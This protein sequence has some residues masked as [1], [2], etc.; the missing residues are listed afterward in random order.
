MLITNKAYNNFINGRFFNEGLRLTFSIVLP[1]LFFGFLGYLQIGLFLSI[2][3]LLVSVTDSPGPINHRFNGMLVTIITT[4]VVSL[5][6][7]LI[8]PALGLLLIF[9][10]VFGFLFSM[11]AVF[12]ARAAAIGI[13]SLLAAILAMHQPDKDFSIIWKTVY[14]LCGA[15]W[16]LCIS[17][18]SYRIRP[19]KIV[20]QVMGEFVQDLSKY[21]HERA[22]FYDKNA[23]LSAVNQHLLEQQV[24]IQQQQATLSE[25]LYKTRALVNEST[26]KGR[27][28][29]KIY[30]DLVQL[31]ESIMT[32]FHSYNILHNVFDKTEVLAEIKANLHLLGNELFDLGIALKAERRVR[33]QP[34]L[35]EHR[36][37][38]KAKYDTLRKTQMQAGNLE[39]FVTLGRIIKN[40]ERM[41]MQVEDLQVYSSYDKS[42]VTRKPGHLPNENYAEKNDIRFSLLINNL[43]FA[44]NIF[45]HSIRVAL[46]LVVGLAVARSLAIGHGYWVLLTIA[47]ILKPAY[48]LTKQR[49]KD[50][51]LGTVLGLLLAFLIL[52]LAPGKYVLLALIIFFML[53]SFTFLRTNYFV[54]VLFMTAFIILF[55]FISFPANIGSLLVD[56]FIDTLIGSGIALIASLFIVP[57]WEKQEILNSVKLLLIGQS[58][59]LDVF[60]RIF[61][62]GEKVSMQE[63]R[64]SRREL[65]VSQANV[66]GAF[67]RML[68]EPKRFQKNA[69]QIQQFVAMSHILSSQFAALSYYHNYN[70]NKYYSAALLPVTTASKQHLRNAVSILQSQFPAPVALLDEEVAEMVRSINKPYLQARAEEI[71]QGIFESANKGLLIHS[72]AI[73]AQF[74]SIFTSTKDIYYC[75]DSMRKLK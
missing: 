65:L 49:N 43:S 5:F 51:I 23:D 2:G 47:V 75:I 25:M 34:V 13:A 56:R 66:S 17:I 10:L 74:Y 26:H 14:Q 30:I 38:L 19:Y 54:N 32:S 45:R 36:L 31:L 4:T 53:I 60:I 71:E 29:M 27:V 72:Q 6:I 63:I 55:F 16:Y 20:Q 15:I 22:K 52:L 18:L 39:A 24:H 41:S 50:R 70:R 48:S 42:I 37:A 67:S 12:G 1:A 35:E 68:S 73:T 64:K 21:L 3:A 69:S 40:V 46:A 33:L 8:Y 59:F 61:E 58:N 9:F 7:N 28:L 62:K 11:L 44:S 57:V